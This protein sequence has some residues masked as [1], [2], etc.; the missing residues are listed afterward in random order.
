M[1]RSKLV[2]TILV[3]VATAGAAIAAFVVFFLPRATG[4][5]AHL[6][7]PSWVEYRESA[8]HKSH[9]GRDDVACKDCHAYEK[10][11]FK[12]PGTGPCV[13][14]H[15]KQ[16]AHAHKGGAEKKT[17]C[18]TCH[19][20]APNVVTPTCISCHAQAEGT[21]A[22]IVQHKTTACAGCHKP[23]GDPAT[24][25]KDC[26]SSGCHVDVNAARHAKHAGS[27]DCVDCH[28]PHTPGVAAR[29]TCGGCHQTPA[30]P[31][32]AGHDS[33]M[34]CHKPHDFVAGG[35]NACVGCHTAKPTLL[36]STVA[37]HAVCTSCHTP[38]APAAAAGACTSCHGG[39]RVGHAGKTACIG[40]HAP[41]SGNPNARASTCTSCHQKIATNDKGA[42]A[43]GVACAGCH[44]GHD[45]A[46]PAKGP[47]CATCHTNEVALVATN[48][49]HSDCA[50]CHGASTH[51]P[52]SG[53]A[54][55]TCHKAEAA[56]APRGHQK[57]GGCHQPHSG[58]RTAQTAC[59]SCHANQT[60][61]PH[62]NVKGA[63]ESCHRAHGP[64]GIAG[65]PSCASCHQRA[66][67]PALH[68]VAS[69]ATCTQCHS[70]HAPPRNDRAT[71]TGSC[72]ANKRDHQPQA[73]VCTGCHVF[74]K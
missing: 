34:T 69:H 54:C 18:L 11:G 26:S 51:K 49:G 64:K 36:A 25:T 17:D 14:C 37:P 7:P 62:A 23:H 4:V 20:F 53:L 28:K 22:S 3:I 12:N 32:P 58:A 31:K 16:A 38:H 48:K 19:A 71:C 6:V 29:A 46:V 67:L 24:V 59:A 43:G 39:I 52:T 42:H 73:Q 68:A 41:H 33:C 5:P 70:S 47:L 10:E 56:S 13:K 60:K 50:S 40:C 15:D 27:K 2:L 72:H 44:Q 66:T 57:C 61:G 1:T 45:F 63:C 9:V 35:S 21:L 8:G 65:P 74:R 30:G 55:A